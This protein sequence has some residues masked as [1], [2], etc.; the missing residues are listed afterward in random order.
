[1]P[2]QAGSNKVV[3]DLADLACRYHVFEVGNGGKTL[4]EMIR[5]HRIPDHVV[6]CVR[7]NGDINI[8]VIPHA[9]SAE[10]K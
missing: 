2:N 6:P 3:P 5:N 1:M 4:Q 9:N 7:D 8:N 10:I